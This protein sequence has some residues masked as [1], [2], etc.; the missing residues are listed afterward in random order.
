[1]EEERVS[2]L[3]ARR[4]LCSRREAERYIDEGRV[5]VNGVLVT[6]QGTKAPVNAEIDFDSEKLQK[7]TVAFNKP[8]GVISNLPQGD[9]PEAIE[10][11][12]PENRYDKGAP[13]DPKS[14][15]VVGRLDVNSKG[16]LLFSSDGRVAK[17]IIGPDSE[18]EKEYI[19]RF[20]N[21]VSDTA[22][23]RL[24]FGLK[25]DGQMLKRA[26]V[27]RAGPQAISIV[28][29]EGKNRQIRRMCEIV[30]LEIL[31]LKRVRIGN[32]QL[33]SLPVGMWMVVSYKE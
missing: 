32:I 31:S 4:G 33:G 10:F 21:P 12:V 5:R 9:Y 24:R 15:H 13:I 7:I 16:L 26:E 22:M 19:V 23:S 17:T 30:G 18:V 25:L 8:L 11:I 14:L 27:N 28:L 2:K 3:M 20:K 6:E 1:M 29:R